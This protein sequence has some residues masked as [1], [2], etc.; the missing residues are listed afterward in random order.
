MRQTK[1]SS[2]TENNLTFTTRVTERVE[3]TIIHK[4]NEEK[5]KHWNEMWSKNTTTYTAI[6]GYGFLPTTAW[7]FTDY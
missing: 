2:K 1:S 3:L 6:D 4:Q 7:L 5:V